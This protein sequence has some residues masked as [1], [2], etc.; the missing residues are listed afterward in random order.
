MKLIV[1][2]GNPGSKYVKTRHNIGFEVISHFVDRLGAS[3][4]SKKQYGALVGTHTFN[5][6]KIVFA[7]PQKFMNLSGQPVASLM[8][9]YKCTSKDVIVVHDE[10]DIPFS[11]VRIKQKG[12]HGGHNGLRDIIKHIG[13]EFIR[14]RAGIGRPPAGWET[15]NFVLS[16]W[17][18]SE[19]EEVEQLK[20]RAS[21]ALE[22]LLREGLRTSMQ[23]F[24]TKI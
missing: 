14:V 11:T 9:Y 15:A 24:N 18:S 16:K 12:G 10:L 3:A 1:G 17:K 21:D 8:G 4:P 23:T 5:D 22:A 20:E 13:N 6:T 2:L 7:L 19:E